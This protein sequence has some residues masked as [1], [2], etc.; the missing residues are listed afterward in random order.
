MIQME[1]NFKDKAGKHLVCAT[2]NKSI[3]KFHIFFV[4]HNLQSRFRSRIDK[5]HK[6]KSWKCQNDKC[7]FTI[8]W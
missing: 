1:K 2:D 4:L 8:C 7:K 5:K 6:K 3:L